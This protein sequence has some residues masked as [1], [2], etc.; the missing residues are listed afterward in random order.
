[1][2]KIHAASIFFLIILTIFIQRVMTQELFDT[3]TFLRSGHTD[4][5]YA[6]SFSPDGTRIV[7][8]SADNTVKMWDVESGR[9][10]RTFQ[11]HFGSVFSVAFSPNNGVRLEDRYDLNMVFSTREVAHR[12]TA[13]PSEGAI[14][15][16]VLY[17]G[18]E[19]SGGETVLKNESQKYRLAGLSLP[20]RTEALP[21]LTSRERPD[22]ISLEAPP[23]RSRPYR[24]S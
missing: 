5:I 1:M 10:I 14:G 24:N 3:E 22:G 2:K 21:A 9:V 12:N 16:A 8:G 13:V 23:P 17:G 4:E 7:S 11:G 19:Y 20:P 18:I 6:L 15:S